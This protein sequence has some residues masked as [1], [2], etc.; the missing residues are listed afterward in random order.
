M[1]A[2]AAPLALTRAARF[3]ESSIGKKTVMAVTGA[4]LFVF[5][6]GHMAGN[7][8]FYLGPEALNSYAAHLRDLGPLLWLVR[9]VLFACVLAHIV[10]ALQ[11]WMINRQARPTPYRKLSATTSTLASRTMLYSGPML[12]AF[13]GYHLYHLTLGPHL[14]HDPLTGH[15]LAYQN[16]VAGFRD[17]VASGLY[18]VAMA[19]LGLH[20][21]HG[22]WSMF[23]S[24]GASHPRYT[25]VLRRFALLAA[26]AIVA[27]NLSIPLAVLAG[28]H[29]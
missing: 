15:P 23:Q 4:V 1:S 14:L 5:V 13:V 3:Y 19:F 2:A 24:V 8:Q 26:V 16:V 27:G 10:A 17:P 6:V 29:Q 20:L 18:L 28:F 21:Y 11:L 12:A 22:T 7:L 25:P 9:A